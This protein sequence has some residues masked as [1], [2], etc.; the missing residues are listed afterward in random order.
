MTL[1]TIYSI[2][3]SL[4]TMT[5]GILL[6]GYSGGPASITGMGYTGAPGDA[7]QVCGSCHATNSFGMCTVTMT[8]EDEVPTYNLLAPTPIEITVNA[9]MGTPSG[10]GFQLIALNQDDTPLDVTYS[11]ISANAKETVTASGRKY[12]EQNGTSTSNTFTFDFQPNMVNGT[13]IRFYVVGN[14]VNAD[15]G[16]LGDSG[17]Q[18]FMFSIEEINLAVE[19][20][21]FAATQ[22]KEGIQLDW[23]TETEEDNEY[24]AVE[25]SL[26]GMDFT[27]L[28]TIDG[29]GTTQERQAYTY[30]HDAP[31][32][33]ANYYRLRIVEFSG[34][35]T[36]SE[37]LVEKF[38]AFD[39]VTAFPQPAGNH[40]TL[41]VNARVNEAAIL[42]V[43]DLMGRTIHTENVSLISG[44]NLIDIHCSQWVSG[45]YVIQIQGEQIGEETVRFLK[46]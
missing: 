24:F 18:S 42:Q 40:A 39:T 43:H 35:T 44:E 19:L 29:A 12:L 5:L 11:N 7:M 30:V 6:V 13:E 2:F 36:Y 38:Y 33:G 23:R 41:Y 20:S 45:H 8:S 37:V 28:K 21:D 34:K 31:V 46:K 14:A 4:L 3:F 25:H 26:N 22:T 10:Y 32:N 15:G 9:A 17:S 27:T 1:K 16:T